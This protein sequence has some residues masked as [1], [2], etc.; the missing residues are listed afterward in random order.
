[1]IRQASVIRRH[2][3]FSLIEVIIYIALSAAIITTLL[4]VTLTVLQAQEGMQASGTVRESIDA[5]M[6]HIVTSLSSAED[7]DFAHTVFGSNAGKL[8]L[9]M[10]GAGLQPTVFSLSGASIR[11][12]RGSITALLT[13]SGIVV[14]T[15][16]FRNFTPPGSQ[17]VIGVQIHAT[18]THRNSQGRPMEDQTLT[19]SVTL[20]Q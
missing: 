13:G 18:S 17:T 3:A 5:A 19:T 8:A 16:L 1:M 11:E 7:V 12:R 20:R 14:D 2:R 10:S 9:T 6:T 15:L 4:R